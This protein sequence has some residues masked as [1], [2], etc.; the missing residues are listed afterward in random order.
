MP[1]GKGTP[2][3]CQPAPKDVRAQHAFP[4]RAAA[5]AAASQMSRPG[6]SGTRCGSPATPAAGR[7][8][9]HVTIIIRVVM[10]IVIV[11]V[12]V[13]V[14]VVVIVLIICCLK[15]TIKKKLIIHSNKSNCR[16]RAATR[17]ALANLIAGDVGAQRHTLRQ[18]NSE[19]S[20]CRGPSAGTEVA[21]SWKRYSGGRQGEQ[22]WGQLEGHDSTPDEGGLPRQGGRGETSAAFARPR[23]PRQ[24][25]TRL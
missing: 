15:H 8:V 18:R 3:W 25:C 7:A 16:G 23:P 4:A 2:S 10:V 21:L 1:P 20:L 9:A 11:V 14:I 22:R 5:A 6:G 12:V 19:S 24:I 17:S 13:I